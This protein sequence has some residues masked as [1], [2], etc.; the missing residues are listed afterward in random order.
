MNGRGTYS[1][2]Y[3]ITNVR[4]VGEN[5]DYDDGSG[6]SGAPGLGQHT[7]RVRVYIDGR[8][9]RARRVRRLVLVIP[10][11]AATGDWLFLLQPQISA[12]Q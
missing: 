7:R 8:R 3:S 12:M 9:A 10:F 6:T 5:D 11:V 4:Q 2:Y 1:S